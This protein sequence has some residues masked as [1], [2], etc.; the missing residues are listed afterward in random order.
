MSH[1]ALVVTEEGP[2]GV[3]SREEVAKIIEHHFGLRRYDFHILRGS[4]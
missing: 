3:T 4:P 1:H 2:R